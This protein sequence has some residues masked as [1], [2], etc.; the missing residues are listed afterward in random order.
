MTMCASACPDAGC[1]P[2]KPVMQKQVAKAAVPLQP[3]E[4]CQTLLVSVDVLSPLRDQPQPTDRSDPRWAEA[5]ES[6]RSCLTVILKRLEGEATEGEEAS[7]SAQADTRGGVRELLNLLLAGSLLA[8]LLQ[9][10]LCVLDFEAQKD[11]VRVFGAV[12]RLSATLG[13]EGQVVEYVHNHPDLSRDLVN[14]CGRPEVAMHCGMM[15]R[16]CVRYPQLVQILFRD[17]VAEELIN[18]AQHQSFDISSDAFSSLRELLLTHKAE[19][20]AHLEV[21]FKQ[22]FELYHTLLAVDNYVTQRQALRLLGELLLNRSFVNAMLAYV[23]T[24]QFLQIHMNLLRDSSKAI[25]IESFHVFKIF[26]VNPRKPP[27]VQQILFRN[28]ERLVRL[29]NT[30][31]GKKIEDEP[32]TKDLQ[33]VIETLTKLTMPSATKTEPSTSAAKQ[34]PSTNSTPKSQE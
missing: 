34:E 6:M 27:R 22:F 31:F 2:W 32:F 26:V 3:R 30:F 14:G 33:I 9:A 10:C 24:E 19:A 18:L 29:L 20:S 25:Q 5:G 16:S 28:R 15:L 23:G 4:L 7:K 8:R 17:G 1:L 11:V 21:H 12:L 13:M